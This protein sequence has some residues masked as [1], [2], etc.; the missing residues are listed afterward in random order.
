M[1]ARGLHAAGS[2]RHANLQGG[3]QFLLH[4]VLGYSSNPSNLDKLGFGRHFE[5][6]TSVSAATATATALS[7]HEMLISAD[8]DVLSTVHP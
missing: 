1:L 4:K 7:I 8:A 3:H 5:A 6:A 2:S